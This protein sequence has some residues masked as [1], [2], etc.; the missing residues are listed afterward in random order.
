M[1]FH[2]FIRQAGKQGVDIFIVPGDE[3]ARG[4]A[5]FHTELSMLRAVENGFS[6]VRTTLEGLT[7]GADYQGRV[8]SQLNF[9]QTLSDRSIITEIPVKGVQTIYSRFGDWFA[10]MCTL[11]LI[12]L[13][14]IALTS[15]YVRSSL[16]RKKD[17]ETSK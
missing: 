13:S 3:P 1:E 15:S 11:M 9:Y 10:W 16:L 2:R 7:M 4:A 6:M 14:V 5:N 8:L 17:F 12:I